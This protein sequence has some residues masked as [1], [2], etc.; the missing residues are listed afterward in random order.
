MAAKKSTKTPT[1]TK[2]PEL[3]F[4]DLIDLDAFIAA[5]TDF[6][7]EPALVLQVA[8]ERALAALRVTGVHTPIDGLAFPV[9]RKG[10]D[11]LQDALADLVLRC[12]RTD[13]LTT[14]DIDAIRAAGVAVY[15]WQAHYRVMKQEALDKHLADQQSD[16][17]AARQRQARADRWR[18]EAN[19]Q[20][21][22]AE[23][24]KLRATH[25]DWFKYQIEDELKRTFF[26]VTDW[27]LTFVTI[28]RR[29]K[30]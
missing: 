2:A 26:G 19:V 9:S 17:K 7:D 29:R 22:D 3:V 27:L 4:G 1:R 6:A 13:A 23:A 24:I 10:F 28:P 5:V 21:L 30:R 14:E 11:V 18:R 16:A 12:R 20:A 25:P 15:G 8:Q